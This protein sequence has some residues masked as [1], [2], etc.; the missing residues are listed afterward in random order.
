RVPA[1]AAVP[2][3]ADPAAGLPPPGERA[4][5]AAAAA[6]GAVGG[7]PRRR[8]RPALPLRAGARLPGRDPGRLRRG[9]V[10]EAVPVV[11]RAGAA[12]ARLPSGRVARRGRAGRAAT[13]T[14]GRA[15]RMNPLTLPWLELSVAVPL[16][17]ALCV[18]RMRDAHAAYRCCV[19]FT[20]VTLAC[21]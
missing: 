5:L 6:G 16:A 9:P 12:G 19:A 21:T 1:D 20:G 13:R 3:G 4:G 2:A 14:P 7:R 15:A 10:R 8:P 11:R 18:G 17:G